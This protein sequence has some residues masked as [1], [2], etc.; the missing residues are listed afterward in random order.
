MNQI[1]TTEERQKR[2]KEEAQRKINRSNMQQHADKII[3][4]F[5]KLGP[6]EA[7]RS[8]WEL[9]QN[10]I[11][12][13]EENSIIE[14][15]LKPN[16]LDFSH[17]GVPFTDETLN[18]LIKQV[19]S[20]SN[21]SNEDA[22]GQ[23]GTGFLTTHSLGK[24][25]LLSGAIQVEEGF[26]PFENFE[27][28]RRAENSDRDILI[29]KLM[30][31]E[32]KYLALLS[33][34]EVKQHL[35]HDQTVLSYQFDSPSNRE[36]AEVAMEALEEIVPMVITISSKLSEVRVKEN[37]ALRTRFKKGEVT[38]N[39]NYTR[40]SIRYE[41][42]QEAT[43]ELDIYSLFVGDSLQIL[44]PL[45]DIDT[46]YAPSQ[47][48]PRLFL[49]YP[50]M[51]TEDFGT[52]FIIHSKE[53]APTEPRD[54]LHLASENEQV[55]AKEERNRQLL[56]QASEAIWAF[57]KQHGPKVA[58]PIH[59]AKIAFPQPDDNG[60]LK[61]YFD[62]L[63]AQWV[64]ELKEVALVETLSGRKKA[65]ESR[66]F[67]RSLWRFE[68]YKAGIYNLACLFYKNIPEAD[69]AEDWTHTVDAWED[70]DL[71]R[72][73]A[74]KLCEQISQQ[75]L[76]FFKE[77][78][79]LKAFYNYLLKA[80]KGQFFTE[81]PLLPNIKG[82]LKKLPQL[83]KAVSTIDGY[84]IRIADELI[85]D[86]PET[87]LHKDF[88][89]YEVE[90]VYEAEDLKEDIAN[91]ANWLAKDLSNSGQRLS[92]EQRKA[93]ISYCSISSQEPDDSTRWQL[94]NIFQNY[95]GEE[96]KAH[97]SSV[98]QGQENFWS[99]PLR[100][101]LRD[102]IREIQSKSPDWVKENLE[103]IKTLLATIGEYSA[104]EKI[105][106]SERLFPNQLHKLCEANKVK[107]ETTEIPERIKE[108]YNGVARQDGE[109]A[110]ESRLLLRDINDYMPNDL[111][112]GIEVTDLS[113]KIEQ[114]LEAERSYTD[115]EEHP[116]KET[117]LELI[118]HMAGK[119]QEQSWSA[120]FPILNE[121]KAT[122]M[123]AAISDE[124][125]RES[126]FS[127]ISSDKEKVDALGKIAQKLSS[128]T[129]RTLSDIDPNDID[130]VIRL[131]KQQL[132]AKKRDE[133]DMRFK[134]GIGE[135]LEKLLLEYLRGKVASENIKVTNEGTGK[136][137]AVRVYNKA[138][139]YIEVKSRWQAHNSVLLSKDQM[140]TA[141][142]HK[143]AY[144]LCYIDMTGYTG[145]EG[146]SRFEVTDV[147][148]VIKRSLFATHIGEKLEALVTA[149]EGSEISLDD[150]KGVVPKR[151]LKEGNKMERFV[152]NT[153]GPKI[154]QSLI[155]F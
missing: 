144:A 96:V 70:K 153:L 14:I 111:A 119:D 33:T 79:P 145:D 37:G 54:G 97:L 98:F 36:N 4:S 74:K 51:G 21:Q 93:L 52:H 69:L 10:A 102:F 6:H 107:V 39:D 152:Q 63:R 91:A 115:L 134:K 8:V 106:K 126:L 34:E 7:R 104:Y 40:T 87:F 60:L 155:N 133:A 50:L 125:R 22:V 140:S 84:I 53:F 117:I 72:V 127:I 103:V 58:H 44:L 94:L 31:Q 147:E 29:E 28:D 35:E 12:L 143:H 45:K 73:T 123:M 26:I 95:Y 77:W 149:I 64:K 57:I 154:K 46:A 48:I 146:K 41:K 118:K 5:E 151:I 139:Y 16:S 135:R 100:C 128:N 110:I 131:G 92:A 19:S 71:E 30:N 136:D 138:V 132:E 109:A 42:S 88:Y 15:N 99:A 18:S 27:I 25:I 80:E 108:I 13:R 122:V 121:K 116:H 17:N 9:F 141:S 11:D 124:E 82:T 105:V 81:Y 1:T 55:K 66:F 20:K 32:E 137:L 86:E 67:E 89:D 65:S 114:A 62:K 112:E 76:S 130:E 47:Q 101:L 75:N 56:E 61:A 3:Q 90:A 85:P 2:R 142:K 148:E 59:L 113:S 49:Y 23:Y 78:Q 150:Y 120:Y 83:Q 68:A 38:R 24:R 129:L 43:T